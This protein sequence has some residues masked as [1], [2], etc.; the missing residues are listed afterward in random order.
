MLLAGFQ[1]NQ[2]YHHLAITRSYLK[3]LAAT[4]QTLT[5]V[6]DPFAYRTDAWCTS[7]FPQF[8]KYGSKD[9]GKGNYFCRSSRNEAPT[10]LVMP[11]SHSAMLWYGLAASLPSESVANVAMGGCIPF[12]SRTGAEPNTC[13]SLDEIVES[14]AKDTNLKALVLVDYLRYYEVGG[15]YWVDPHADKFS[16]GTSTS[17]RDVMSN[18]IIRTITPFLE[19]HKQVF[20]VLDWPDLPFEPASCIGLRPLRLTAR[21]RRPC[22]QSRADFESDNSTRQRIITD[23]LKEHPQVHVID[24]AQPLCDDRWCWAMKDGLPMYFD[25]SHLS[26]AGSRYVARVIAPLIR[27]Q[28]MGKSESY[29]VGA[30]SDG[31]RQP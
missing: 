19:N 24:A 20:F 18:S 29:P 10:V 16:S 15:D 27:A 1:G 26:I 21:V 31:D 3:F 13:H 9:P 7:R 14:A 22:A 30:K 23:I 2:S 8:P 28:L 25:R 5:G 17:Y 6:V 11:D 4:R 12:T